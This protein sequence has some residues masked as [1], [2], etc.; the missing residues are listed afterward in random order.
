MSSLERLLCNAKFMSCRSLS[1]LRYV[2]M[3]CPGIRTP[4]GTIMRVIRADVLGMCFGVRD[5]LAVIDK[6]VEPQ[7]IT[8][9]GELVHNQIVQLQ[10]SARGFAMRAEVERKRS[11]PET[12]SV[13]ITA[14]GI[15]DRERMRLESAG[16][17]LVD[18]TCPLVKR[19][20]LAARALEAEGWYVLVIGRRGHVE[21]EGVIEDL[22][23][24]DVIECE[25]DVR[26]Y[27]ALRLGIVC[28]TT[29]TER[30]V[31]A[32]KSAVAALNPGAEIKFVDTVC[33]PTKEHQRA[34]EKLLDQVE[35]VVVVGGRSS[36]NT[37]QL[38]ARCHERGKPALHVQSTAELDPA[39][40][41]PFATVG[42]TAGTSTLLETIDEIHRAL[43]WI[44]SGAANDAGYD[45]RTVPDRVC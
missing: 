20:H 43:V 17:E 4:E 8:I 33:H 30:S 22:E 34:L 13:L 28:Q 35:A 42:L 27:P 2:G 3:R 21:V 18:T 31:A 5:S 16:K 11:L 15:S 12:P 29:A 6:I 32:I 39:W 7:A 19:V 36:N 10:L 26:E 14:H 9:H 1:L 45:G 38:V 44:G 40:F 23:H 41:K 25:S 24:F 37:R